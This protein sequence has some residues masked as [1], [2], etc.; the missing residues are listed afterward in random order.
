MTIKRDGTEPSVSYDSAVGTQGSDGWYTSEVTATFVATDT[1]SG[2]DTQS[3]TVTSSGEGSVVIVNSPAFEDNAG[4]TAAAAIAFKS[5]KIDM[6][7]PTN[8]S[9]EGG[10]TSGSGYYFGSVPAAPTCNASD[11]LSGLDGL[12]GHRLLHRRR[13]SHVDRNGHRQRRQ[14]HVG[15]RYTVLAWTAN[16]FYSPVDM[17]GVWN[18]VKGGSTVPLKFE[19][20]AGPTELTSTSA[21]AT[22]QTQ[23]VTLRHVQRPGGRHRGRQHRRDQPALRHT[24]GQ[25]IQN[26]KTPAGAGT[27]Y[28]ATMTQPTGRASPHCSSSSER[29]A[30]RCRMEEGPRF[31]WGLSCCSEG[32]RV[33]RDA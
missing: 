3:N 15:H 30:P 12:R 5:F 22:F 8:I 18:T 2:P 27:C 9:F 17:G 26:W 6:S 1:L 16:G 31:A 13:H 28:T 23:K 14:H 32:C 19:L 24:G 4:N 10:P 25:F 11:A 20:F 21:V 33:V 7:K 29:S